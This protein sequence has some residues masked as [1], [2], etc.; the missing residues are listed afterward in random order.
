MLGWESIETAPRDGTHVDVW[1][2]VNNIR[3]KPCGKFGRRWPD[4]HYF[5]GHWVMDH[6]IHDENGETIGSSRVHLE[7]HPRGWSGVVT[8]WMPI[9]EGP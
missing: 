6:L 8:H 9:P 3:G 5:D 7:R 1:Y 4:A 2:V